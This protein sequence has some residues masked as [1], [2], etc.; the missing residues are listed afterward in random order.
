MVGAPSLF[1]VC[2]LA[3]QQLALLAQRQVPLGKLP[4]TMRFGHGDSALL[5]R[6]VTALLRDLLGDPARGRGSQRHF[7]LEV[8]HP[9]PQALLGNQQYA[10][11]AR[12]V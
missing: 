2:Q 11:H 1:G 10:V 9:A 6:L 8:F 12:L 4:R 5:A 3:I 7:G